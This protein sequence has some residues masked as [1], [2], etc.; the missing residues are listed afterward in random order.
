MKKPKPIR[1]PNKQ[2]LVDALTY[3]CPMYVGS[4]AFAHCAD[5]TNCTGKAALCNRVTEV[6]KAYAKILK[7]E[8]EVL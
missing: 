3:T 8:I 7:G 2:V 5:G 6:L 4:G 1:I